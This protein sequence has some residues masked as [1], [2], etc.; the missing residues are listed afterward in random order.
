MAKHIG[1]RFFFVLVAIVADCIIAGAICF[2]INI[3]AGI[4]TAVAVTA[5]LWDAFYAETVTWNHLDD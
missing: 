2:N 5:V 3:W 4:I 1:K